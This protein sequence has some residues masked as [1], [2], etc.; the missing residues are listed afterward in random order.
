MLPFSLKLPLWRLR[1]EWAFMTA[2]FMA[3]AGSA[4][5]TTPL[6]M[7]HFGVM[8]AVADAA[9][10]LCVVALWFERER[11]KPVHHPITFG[12]EERLAA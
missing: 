8:T 9:L 12:D 1:E 6:M 10:V 11:T 4:I 2:L 5:P 7:G 3:L